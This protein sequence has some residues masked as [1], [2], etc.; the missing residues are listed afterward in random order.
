M[1]YNIIHIDCLQVWCEGGASL[2]R[3]QMTGVPDIVPPDYSRT[4]LEEVAHDI[5]TKVAVT[6]DHLYIDDDCISVF[7]W[8]VTVILDSHALVVYVRCN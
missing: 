1:Y 8:Q 6:L 7:H 2:L 5:T 3:G 4:N